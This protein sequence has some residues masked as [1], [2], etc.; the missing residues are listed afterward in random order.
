MKLLVSALE[1]SA[2]IYLQDILE[3]YQDELEIVGIFDEKFGKPKYKASDFAVMGLLEVVDKIGLA[4]LA[5]G[6]M[7]FMAKDVDKVLLIDSPAFNLP[8]AKSLKLNYPNLEIIYYILPKVWAWKKGRAKKVDKYC[9][10]LCSIFPFE[11]RYYKKSEYVGNPLLDSINVRHNGEKKDQIAF[12]PGSRKGEI[13]RLMPVFRELAKD[14]NKK[15][16]LVIPKLFS[17]KQ[18]KEYYADVSDFELSYNT[19]ETLAQSDFAYICSGTATLESAIIGTPFVLVYKARKFDFWIGRKLVKLPYVGLAN[20]LLSFE[21][22]E[23]LHQELLQDDVT[24]DNLLEAYHNIDEEKFL[25]RSK[26]IID[27]LKFGSR[28]RVI[29]ILKKG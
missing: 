15:K 22:K 4:K 25:K 19:Y 27:I 6:D 16:V 28:D 24:F 8:L 14:I 1:P 9:D 7:M 11:N 29:E 5:M 10:R 12:L 18:V 13:K 3:S 26:E 21:G 23:P 17:Q 2:N 20:I